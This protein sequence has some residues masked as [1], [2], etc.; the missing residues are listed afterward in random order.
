MKRKAEFKMTSRFLA[1]VTPQEERRFK[2]PRGEEG[3]SGRY[4][5]PKDSKR[6]E[7]PSLQ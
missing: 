5:R 4:F 3:V 7:W 6:K 1:G 2:H